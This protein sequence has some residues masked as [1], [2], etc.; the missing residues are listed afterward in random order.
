M[1]VYEKGQIIVGLDFGGTLDGSAIPPQVLRWDFYRRAGYQFPQEVLRQA[2]RYT[3]ERILESQDRQSWG[4]AVAT[5]QWFVYEAEYLGLDT[6]LARRWAKQHAEERRLRFAEVHSVILDLS[7]DYKLVLISNNIGNLEKVLS[8]VG[9][10]SAFHVVVD[11][12]ECGFRKPDPRIF[13]EAQTRMGVTEGSDCWYLG[14]KYENDVIGA[15]RAGWNAAWLVNCPPDR[16]IP[17]GVLVV[18]SIEELHNELNKRYR[19]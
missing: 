4:L 14:D 16:E 10:R 6:R 5:E 19:S 18:S 9:L 2:H 8:E 13:Y 12:P 1:T 7:L 3:R 15:L 17:V 11:S